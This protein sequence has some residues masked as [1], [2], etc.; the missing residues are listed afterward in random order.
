MKPLTERLYDALQTWP[1][2]QQA[3]AEATEVLIDQLK[4]EI[5]EWLLDNAT[6]AKER[7]EVISARNYRDLAESVRR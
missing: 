2:V 6:A 5:E 7:G 3:P 1:A 4:H